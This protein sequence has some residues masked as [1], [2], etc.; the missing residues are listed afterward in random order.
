MSRKIVKKDWGR[1]EYTADEPEYCGKLLVIDP[2]W[3]CSKHMH[4]IKKETF[5]VLEGMVILEIGSATVN[6][7]KGDRF[8]IL[9]E[10]K[11]RFGSWAGA[12][13][14]ETSTHHED[15]DVVRFENS[16]PMKKDD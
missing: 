11:H 1:E 13:L 12:T 4:P 9:P 15:E 3:Q 16:R 7:I 2:G 8:T 5:F 10:T 6:A 14:V